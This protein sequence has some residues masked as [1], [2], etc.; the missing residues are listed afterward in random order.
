MKYFTHHG[1]GLNIEKAQ[2]SQVRKQATQLKTVATKMDTIAGMLNKVSTQGSW[3]SPA[4][5]EFASKVGRTPKDLHAIAKR[6]SSA[7]AVISPYAELLASSQKSL[8][9]WDTKAHQA[10]AT[11]KS[12]DKELEELSADDPERPQVLKE[13][14][15]AAA[16]LSRAERGFEREVTEAEADESRMAK[17][18]YDL[19]KKHGDPRGYDFLEW[20]TNTGEDASKV[21][22]IAKPIALAGVAKPLGMAGRRGFYGEGSWGDVSKAGGGYV[23]D[24]TG[25]G[26][27]RVVNKATQRFSDKKAARL[28]ELESKPVLMQD[29]PL[30][31][32]F[33]PTASTNRAARR[34]VEAEGP[35]PKKYYEPVPSKVP[36]AVRDVARRKSGMDDVAKAL[37]DWE[38]VAGAGRVAK[39]AV[40]V[41][42]SAK[43]GNRV[44]KT[45]TTTA[46]GLNGSG[47]TRKGKEQKEAQRRQRANARKTAEEPGVDDLVIKPFPPPGKH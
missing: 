32:P 34:K 29:N 1:Q 17:K 43:H 30:I 5:D 45:T 2:P 28:H 42:H 41:E 39:V 44:R 31:K 3:E 33:P 8:S 25:F 22:I 46:N 16:A 11:M 4:G 21:G 14:G 10:Q 27:G 37:D 23:L 35:W 12:K 38:A 7:A 15:E 20:M 19:S 6:L 18:L 40:V 47:A 9:A 36:G 26:A 24:T 13:R